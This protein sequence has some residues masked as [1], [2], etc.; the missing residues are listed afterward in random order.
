MKH[1]DL[2]C[3]DVDGTL[4][5][6]P[7]NKVIWEVLNIKILGDDG[8]NKARYKMYCDGA[9]TYDEWVRLD[10]QGWLDRGATRDQILEAVGEFNLIDGAMETVHELKR[11]GYR[12]AIISG[13]LNVVIDALF[14]D[15][16]FEEV[17]SNK[18]FF[19]ER[20]RLAS[21]KATPFDLHGKPVALKALAHE[22]GTTLERSAF[23]GDGDNDVPLLGVAGYFVAFNPRSN[24]LEKGSDVV[25]RGRNLKKLLEI[26][27]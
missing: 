21:W 2:I 18:I 4:V 26:F 19:D 8:I 3:F 1:Y 22:F 16:P 17:F 12:L 23:V 11:R 7:R 20:G 13:T 27:E 25:V 15:H 5:E 6:H 14:P 9:I 10:V 24:E